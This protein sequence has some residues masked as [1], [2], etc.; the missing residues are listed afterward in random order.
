MHEMS[1][2]EAVRD[3]LLELKAQEQWG[4]VE[5]VVL[6]IGAMRQV[7]PDVMTFC[8]DVSVEGTPLEGAALEIVPVPLTWRCR[9]CG[10]EWSGEAVDTICP[11]CGS[12]DSELQQGMELDIAYVEVEDSDGDKDRNPQ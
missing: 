11:K 10:E 6:N 2:V 8:F 5:R 4:D 12:T 1:L 9:E 3:T 7:I